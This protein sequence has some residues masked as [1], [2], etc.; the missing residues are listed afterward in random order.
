MVDAVL[1]RPPFVGGEHLSVS[2]TPE[3]NGN[4]LWVASISPQEASLD[5]ATLRFTS[6]LGEIVLE[7]VVWGEVLLC[8]GQSN[9][10]GY[11][12]HSTYGP[13]SVASSLT[14]EGIYVPG[15]F[16]KSGEEGVKQKKLREI[17]RRKRRG[18]PDP[19]VAEV[20][21]SVVHKKEDENV[22]RDDVK[23]SEGK[24]E[25]EKRQEEKI[26]RPKR[27]KR[28]KGDTGK[29]LPTI[30]DPPPSLRFRSRV[31]SSSS[32]SSS[33]TSSS[34]SSAAAA[35]AAE[36]GFS[37]RGWVPQ[38]FAIAKD[39][40]QGGEDEENSGEAE[41]D[42]EGAWAYVR[43]QLPPERELPIRV[44][45]VGE[46][47][48][49]ASEGPLAFLASPPVIAWQHAPT[50]LSPSALHTAAVCYHAGRTLAAGLPGVPVGLIESSWGGSFIQS[51]SSSSAWEV[52][53]NSPI[54]AGGW[55]S[56]APATALFNSMIAPFAI[57]PISLGGLIFYIG[58]S[59]ASFDQADYFACAL[60]MLIATWR[61]A[62]A[63]PDMWA[64]VIQ[65]QGWIDGNLHQDNFAAVRDVQLEVSKGGVVP[66]VATVSA[67]D[68]G[69]H[70][71]PFHSIHPR[72]KRVLGERS[73]AAGLAFLAGLP[74]P[75]GPVYLRAVTRLGRG[76]AVTVFF[77]PDSVVGGLVWRT[78][79]DS[80][81]PSSH[82]PS[83]V[84]KHT[85]RWFAI[86][87]SYGTWH[88]ATA[89]IGDNGMTLELVADEGRRGMR[90]AV[91][92]QNGWGLW[93][94]VTLYNAAGLPA[95]PW[96]KRIIKK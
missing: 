19:V 77:E 72:Y 1:V 32:S 44:F 84:P 78:E 22:G 75:R 5:P 74:P 12:Q 55:W 27:G 45:Q 67:V 88:N 41:E 17:A 15:V 31:L 50:T 60:P 21:A 62:F 39:T 28:K 49:W 3:R 25:E 8:S 9:M 35:A 87:D 94:V 26:V 61:S 64:V 57:G 73:G 40:P 54:P 48:S 16:D 37:W 24:N 11:S 82:C 34:S 42:N 71:S 96:S 66:R 43:S 33:S 52:C 2:Y 59:Q 53:G 95:Y 70:T 63:S 23:P 76:L 81:L 10:A 4:S 46:K 93:P 29:Q 38:E 80:H 18:L 47:D 56:P 89:R 6:P 83:S 30:P 79:S 58:E 90:K 69:D 20:P 7:D 91:A 85:C 13:G 68:C 36:K 92:T 14:V 51:W 65:I 86:E